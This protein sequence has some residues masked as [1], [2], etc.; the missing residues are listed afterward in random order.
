MYFS[1]NCKFLRKRR[2]RTQD[3]V[4]TSL[5][6]KRSTLNNYEN[7]ISQ[8]SLEALIAISKYYKVA[9]DTLIKVDL[10]Q[11][12]ESQISQIEK[13]YD[14]FITGSNLRI[15]TTTID[16][17]NKDNIELVAEK[18]K[19]GYKTGYADPEFIKILPTFQLP[20]LSKERKY[21]TFQIKGDSMLP[22]P[23]GAWI[24]GEYV[25]NWNLIRDKY[26]YIILTLDEGIVFK[27]VENKIKT[28]GILRLH[29][30]NPIYPAYNIP[31]TEVKE[32]WKFIHYI[33]EQLP[34]NEGIANSVVLE[35]VSNLKQEIE[36]LKN[37]MEKQ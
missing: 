12:P 3:E 21:R 11:L 29:S 35:S 8:P 15:L 31:A 14:P 18:A 17:H 27:V 1:S 26:A 30:L 32:V 34:Q 37:K 24:T 25:Q 7:S 5:E 33:S 28:E 16:K 36:V 19:A 22:I 9:I 23:D 4:S 10:S 20:F 2:G 13:G 6:M